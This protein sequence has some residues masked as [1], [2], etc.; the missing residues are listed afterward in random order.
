MFDTIQCYTGL[1]RDVFI[2]PE[3]KNLETTF[4]Q[5][6]KM[7]RE[8]CGLRQWQV[9]DIL[10]M[11]RTTYTKYETGVSEPSQGVL[12]KLVALFG[13]DY[14]T[15]LGQDNVVSAAFSDSSLPM[16]RLADKEKELVSLFRDMTKENQQEFI[17][18]AK[19]MSSEGKLNKKKS[20]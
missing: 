10:N 8:N 16:F 20:E 3:R 15:L 18:I 17:K 1:Y 9:A 12:K 5:R 19:Q 2:L 6:L 14:N 7:C 13:V 4:A 11:N